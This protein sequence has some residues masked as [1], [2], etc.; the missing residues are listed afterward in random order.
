M[1]SSLYRFS[2]KKFNKILNT[3]LKEFPEEKKMRLANSAAF[4][5]GCFSDA[6][7][8]DPCLLLHLRTHINPKLTA[9]AVK[10]GLLKDISLTPEEITQIGQC[11]FC[12]ESGMVKPSPSVPSHRELYTPQLAIQKSESNITNMLPSLTLNCVSK[13]NKPATVPKRL[14]YKLENIHQTS[15]NNISNEIIDSELAAKYGTAKSFKTKSSCGVTNCIVCSTALNQNAK[16][17]ISTDD[18]IMTQAEYL[19][20]YSVNKNLS[21]PQKYLITRQEILLRLKLHEYIVIRNG[22]V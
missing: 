5:T 14:K 18:A 19:N 16:F 22:C 8:Q 12:I 4:Q 2:T 17:K 3:T 10:M 1:V 13:R 15:I 21:N 7:I 20:V 9:F 6:K 11:N